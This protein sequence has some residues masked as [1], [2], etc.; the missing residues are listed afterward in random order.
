M[1][2]LRDCVCALV[3]FAGLATAAF[4]DDGDDAVRARLR[5]SL[6]AHLPGLPAIDAI[7]R[8]PIAGLWEIRVGAVVFYAD[9]SGRYVLQGEVRDLQTQ[10]NLTKER[11]DESS[12][13][14]FDDLPLRDALVTRKGDGG[15]RKIAVFADVNCGYCKALEKELAKL[16]GVTVYTFPVAMLGA[17]SR[18]KS[19]AILCA[20]SPEKAWRDWMARGAR[21]PAAK[22]DTAALARNEAYAKRHLLRVTPTIVFA[23]G[24]RH[25][26]IIDAVRLTDKLGEKAALAAP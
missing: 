22:C 21:A 3:A 1:R 10:R 20:K 2:L 6:R 26:G 11:V 15:E 9:G 24:S 14:A 19:A 7:T 18:K 16:D 17:D 12:A 23:D 8:S 4:A 25:E 13:I 5:E